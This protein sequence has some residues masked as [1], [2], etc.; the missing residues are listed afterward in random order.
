[1]GVNI[2]GASDSALAIN[3][4]GTAVGYADEYDAQGSYLGSLAVR[5]NPGDSTAI[6]LGALAPDLFANAHASAINSAGIAIGSSAKYDITGYVGDRAVKWN[7]GST[8]PIELG[9]LGL[10]PN[11]YT[12]TNAYAINPV[13]IVGGTAQKYDAAGNPLG[14]RPVRWDADGIATELDTLGTSATSVANGQVLAIT[15]AGV[16]IGTSQKYDSSGTFIGSRAVRWNAADTTAIELGNL[17]TTE[18]G[19]TVAW[20]S[21]SNASGTAVGYAM[22]WLASGKTQGNRAVRWDAN[23]TAATELGLG[24]GWRMESGNI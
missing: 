14:S 4:A 8:L 19:V 11:G 23:S 12:E 5:W 6:K 15:S 17:G 1:L 2:A 7:A 13:G 21:A 10:A 22:A 24:L 16:A 20:V 9:N 3:A 18:Q